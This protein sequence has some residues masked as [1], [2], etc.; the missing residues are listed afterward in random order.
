M[1]IKFKLQGSI[2]RP[3]QYQIPCQKQAWASRNCRRSPQLRKILFR[4]TRRHKLWILRDPWAILHIFRYWRSN[5]P[6]WL[7]I[8]CNFW[9]CHGS[10]TSYPSSCL[11]ARDEGVLWPNNVVRGKFLGYI[12]CIHLS[13][14]TLQVLFG[15]KNSPDLYHC[16]QTL[17]AVGLLTGLF[18]VVL[19][20]KPAKR[21]GK[22][23]FTYSHF[24]QATPPELTSWCGVISSLQLAATSNTF[25]PAPAAQIRLMSLWST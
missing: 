22:V 18:V 23:T 7:G 5:R 10:N 24:S 21:R 6:F 25:F 4:Q 11:W 20:H 12:Q 17:M 1:S 8:V 19:E 14:L 2:D 15:Q 3:V 13:N 16:V 9:L